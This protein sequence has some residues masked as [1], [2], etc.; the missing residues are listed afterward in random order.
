MINYSLPDFCSGLQYNL[1]FVELTRSCPQFFYD[2][3]RI[4]SL[5][6]CFPSCVLNGGRTYVQ[7]RYTAEQVKATFDAVQQAGLTVRLTFTNMLA[8]PEH[9][10]DEYANMI[11][12]AADGH[13]CE[14]I[15]YS[16][17]LADYIRARHGFKT[18]LSTTRQLADVDEMNRMLDRYDTV[19]LDYMRN[20]DDAYL[21]QIAHPERVEVMP[22]EL[23]NPGCPHRQSHYLHN[24]RQQ[25][26][27]RV[28]PFR[29]CSHEGVGFTSRTA[30]SPTLLGNEDIRRLER[31]Y[32]IHDFKVVGRGVKSELTLE[33]YLYYL[34]KPE[35]RAGLHQALAAKFGI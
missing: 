25:L 7:Q 33:S 17:E 3:V 8:G 27:S 5:Y 12:D 4:A 34:A 32:G 15:V 11:L 19:V 18:V 14:V 13:D 24:S 28:T 22:N 23:C 10:E 9:F 35:H 31:E 16:D 30:Q 26:E 2:D 6:G 29:D 21:S 1:M 20:K